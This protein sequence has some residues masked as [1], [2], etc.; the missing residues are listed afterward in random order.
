MQMANIVWINLK[1]EVQIV[2]KEIAMEKANEDKTFSLSSSKNGDCEDLG[3]IGRM[4]LGIY[5]AID[6]GRKN[7]CRSIILRCPLVMFRGENKK[8]S[9]KR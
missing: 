6:I 4:P 5:I 9:S 2:S 1:Q 3:A 7:T 8:M